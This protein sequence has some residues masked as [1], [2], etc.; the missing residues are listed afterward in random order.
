MREADTARSTGVGEYVAF[1][2][3]SDGSIVMHGE[4]LQMF[5]FEVDRLSFLKNRRSGESSNLIDINGQC[6][7]HVLDH[8]AARWPTD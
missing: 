4:D 1:T 7:A 5:V 8:L 6:S 3:A 2:A